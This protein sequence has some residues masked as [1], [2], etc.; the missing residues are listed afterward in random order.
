MIRAPYAPSPAIAEEFARDLFAAHM[1]PSDPDACFKFLA[2]LY[3]HRLREVLSHANRA[4]WEAG[5]MYIDA[6]IARRVA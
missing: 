5:Q 3:P 6:D 4:E 1:D 2:D